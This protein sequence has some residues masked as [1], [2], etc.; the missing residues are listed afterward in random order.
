MKFDDVLCSYN[1]K[2]IVHIG[3]GAYA[4]VFRLKEQ[5]FI[6]KLIRVFPEWL[7]ERIQSPVVNRISKYMDAY[8]EFQI[9]HALSKLHGKLTYNNINYACKLF[10]FIY[11]GFLT[12]DD[13]PNCFQNGNPDKKSKTDFS[14]VFEEYSLPL[15]REHLLIVMEDC[16]GLMAEH[17]ESLRPYSLLSI[18]K[19][20]ITG[21]AIAEMA[22]EFEHR[23]LH[24]GNIL[25]LPT[26]H[27]CLQFIMGPKRV[28]LPTC[29]YR[30]KII[31]TTF[32]R[33][34]YSKFEVWLKIN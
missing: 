20:I 9:S 26:K 2:D 12:C 6:F 29:G 31:D 5:K 4:D 23:D 19:Q 10:P 32:S 8:N 15:N 1:K 17:L 33:I 14:D 22:L 25:L 18:L 16:G 34:K 21:I 3:S 13:I 28:L 30:V 24:S 7:L 27:R 11:E